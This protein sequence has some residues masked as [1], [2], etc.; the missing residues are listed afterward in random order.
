M[1]K[2]FK[3]MCSGS[4]DEEIIRAFSIP[5]TKKDIRT[6]QGSNWLNDE[7]FVKL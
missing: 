5:I 7:V 2:L 4:D 3:E 6:L 1:I